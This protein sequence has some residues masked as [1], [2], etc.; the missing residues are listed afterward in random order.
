IIGGH[1]ARHAA[2]RHGHL[3]LREAIRSYLGIPR[4]Q[5][6]S[7]LRSGRTLAQIADA[8]PGRSA[9]G[10]REALISASRARLDTKVAAHVLSKRAQQ[11]RI[12]RLETRITALLG[13][14]HP[15]RGLHAHKGGA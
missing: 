8:T 2:A 12:G 13:R 1:P 5:L 11:H 6:L 7:Q 9:S 3:R 10:L 4:R 15:G 14:S